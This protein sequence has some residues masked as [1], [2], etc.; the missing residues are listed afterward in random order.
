LHF[1]NIGSSIEIII[2]IESLKK[3]KIIIKRLEIRLQESTN[4]QN[5][6]NNKNLKIN[7]EVNEISINKKFKN[8]F[9]YF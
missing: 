6:H 7:L 5:N 4:N 8:L 2:I 1:Y 9:F 3:S